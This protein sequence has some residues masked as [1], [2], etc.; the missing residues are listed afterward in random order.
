M[1]IKMGFVSNS[2]SASY[3]IPKKILSEEQISQIKN[4]IEYAQEHFPQIAWAE[5]GQEW[6]IVEIDDNITACT[7]MNNFDIYDFFIAIG[8]KEDDITYIVY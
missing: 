4:H 8:I 2:S 6:D 3:V 5:K 7:G 1:K